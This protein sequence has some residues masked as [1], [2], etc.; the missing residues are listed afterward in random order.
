MFTRRERLGSLPV[1]GPRL[2]C[3]S[4][5]GSPSAAASPIPD[6]YR[7]APQILTEVF[8]AHAGSSLQSV[9]EELSLRMLGVGIDWPAPAYDEF[10]AMISIG[11]RV[12]LGAVDGHR[13]VNTGHQG[14][15]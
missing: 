15:A 8:N 7:L 13:T 14:T 12:E 10:A 6:R 11:R 4:V 9:R 3:R 1:S 2:G 5:N